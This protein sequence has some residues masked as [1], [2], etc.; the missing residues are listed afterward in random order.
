LNGSAQTATTT[1]RASAGRTFELDH[2]SFRIIDIDGRSIAIGA[3]TV[4]GFPRN[5]PVLDEVCNH[6]KLI[7]RFY[8]QAQVV[9]VATF[10]ARS[11]T[12]FPAELSVYGY[13][14]DHGLARAQLYE[15]DVLPRALDAAAQYV[16]VKL[17]HAGRVLHTQHD[18]IE[19]EDVDHEQ[20][21]T[22]YGKP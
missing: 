6:R 20:P 19:T 17:R 15:S 2:V 1:C 16:T 9:H 13:Q 8:P 22:V 4:L 12:A 18:V 10:G 5:D 14:I 7:E 11:S 3:I 21:F